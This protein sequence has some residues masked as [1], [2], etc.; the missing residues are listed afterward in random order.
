MYIHTYVYKYVQIN[1]YHPICI[2][3]LVR[4]CVFLMYIC[5]CIHVYIYIYMYTRVC[6][7]LMYICIFVYVYM[8]T[9]TYTCIHIHIYIHICIFS[10]VYV[11]IYM[12]LYTYI[13][14]YVY[15]YIYIE[16]KTTNTRIFI[17]ILT[18][19]CISLYMYGM[20]SVSKI[21][22]II[23]LFCRILSLWWGSFA[24]ETYN[25]IDPTDQ[26]HPTST[27]IY[28]YVHIHVY[29]HI[30]ILFRIGHISRVESVT[31]VLHWVQQNI[32]KICH[33]PPKSAP[34]GSEDA[35]NTHRMP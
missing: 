23:G 1:R 30:Y 20:A 28:M 2:H 6:V 33:M 31:T 26:S 19:R 11:Y 7:F 35:L 15:I 22:K 17:C 4:L 21:D 14:I 16:T 10:Y 13:C 27:H 3:I 25:F 8:Y 29:M 5:I 24:K 18:G 12:Y 32:S 9:Y 34:Q